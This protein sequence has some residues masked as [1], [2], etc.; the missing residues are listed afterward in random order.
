MLVLALCLVVTAILQAGLRLRHQQRHQL[1]AD[2]SHFSTNG[3][4]DHGEPVRKA[5]RMQSACL[6]YRIYELLSEIMIFMRLAHKLQLFGYIAFVGW[7]YVLV[8]CGH[9]TISMLWDDAPTNNTLVTYGELQVF[10]LYS[11]VL[12][13]AYCVKLNGEICAVIRISWF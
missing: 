9:I 12:Y 10:I 6:N 3:W 13:T 8:T 7:S 11:I 2:F 5:H 1:S 4:T